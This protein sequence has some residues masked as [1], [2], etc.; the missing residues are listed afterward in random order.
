MKANKKE[1]DC[2][3]SALSIKEEIAKEISKLNSS[4]LLTYWKDVTKK[5]P[6]WEKL[7]KLEQ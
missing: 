1:F 7:K 2:V 3:E 6:S 5:N 4:Q